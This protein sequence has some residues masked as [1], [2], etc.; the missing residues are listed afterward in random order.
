MRTCQGTLEDGSPCP[1]ELRPEEDS[2]CPSC[3][4]TRTEHHS[5]LAKVGT[6]VVTV[7]SLLGVGLYKLFQRR[8]DPGV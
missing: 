7:T 3:Q 4:H 6:V 8:N 5:F 2:F 1:R